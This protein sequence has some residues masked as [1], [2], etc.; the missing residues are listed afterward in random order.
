MGVGRQAFQSRALLKL[1][2]GRVL[3]GAR[4]VHG[5]PGAR[6]PP[7]AFCAVSRP[8]GL[9]ACYLVSSTL[10]V[11]AAT[12]SSR[13][14]VLT[15]FFLSLLWPPSVDSLFGTSAHSKRVC[16]LERKHPALAQ[17]WDRA[18]DGAS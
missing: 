16:E 14:E 10:S 7:R 4:K 6:R 9:S 12:P 13:P 3:R 18:K 15:H 17:D 1:D 8:G 2:P 5:A 11:S